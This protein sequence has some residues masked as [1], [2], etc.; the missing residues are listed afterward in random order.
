M[1]GAEQI[2]IAQP[3]VVVG[4]LRVR[5]HPVGKRARPRSGSAHVDFERAHRRG[6]VR[7][8]GAERRGLIERG[9]ARL[10]LARGIRGARRDERLLAS[11]LRLNARIASVWFAAGTLASYTRAPARSSVELR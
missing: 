7:V 5:L 1:R 8:V 9:F 3:D 10:R 6:Q 2:A 11:R 4:L